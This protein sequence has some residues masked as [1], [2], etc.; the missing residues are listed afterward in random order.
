MYATRRGLTL[1]LASLLVAA[2]LFLV[3]PPDPLIAPPMRMRVPSAR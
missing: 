3:R 1:T 2:I